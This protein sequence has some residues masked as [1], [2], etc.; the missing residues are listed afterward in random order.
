MWRN[1]M[2]KKLVQSPPLIK[3]FKTDMLGV[4]I[5]EDR[6]L[7]GQ[8]AAFS[9]SQEMR[10]VLDQK[11]R[12]SIVFA[13]APSQAEFLAG[14]SH[15]E[16]ISWSQVMAF[17]LDEYVG[18]PEDS[19]QNFGYFL[20]QRLFNT[21]QP[22]TVHYING[23]AEDL[24]K[25][26]QHYASLLKEYP[27]DVACIGIG[28]NGHIAFN[29]PELIKIVQPDQTS[30]MQQVHDGCFDKLEKVPTKALTLT[31]SAILSAEAI[32]CMV[33]GK[34][35]A[36]AVKSTLECPVATDCPASVLRRHERAVLYLDRESA[37]ML[38]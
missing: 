3:M 29:D 25:E 31:V 15:A 1:Q 20:R 5:Y 30:R 11:G 24:G 28:E 13:S 34:S 26:C 32:F 4:E 37:G 35:K 14:L 2:E 21:V 38:R 8:A 10:S 22:G 33:P 7:L 6:S 36:P 16:D 12:L 27:L 19:P 18:L 9:V 23:N 17:H